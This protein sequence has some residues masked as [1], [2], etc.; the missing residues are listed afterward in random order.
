MNLRIR[1][2]FLLNYVNLQKHVLHLEVACGPAVP[3]IRDEAD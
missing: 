2:F 1:E 3:G